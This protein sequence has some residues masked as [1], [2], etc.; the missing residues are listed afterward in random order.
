M[1]LLKSLKGPFWYVANLA[2]AC[3][4]FNLKEMADRPRQT[5]VKRNFY[6]L[7]LTAETVLEGVFI[8]ALLTFVSASAILFL[9]AR[10]IYLEIRD[11][12]SDL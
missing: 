8:A 2:I 7:I 12:W 4:R 1:K 5:A 10:W 3:W 6:R 11:T 9:P